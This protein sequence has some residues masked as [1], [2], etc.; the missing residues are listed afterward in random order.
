MVSRRKFK[1][2]CKKLVHLSSDIELEVFLEKE[3][4]KNVKQLLSINRN[5]CNTQDIAQYKIGHDNERLLNII[6]TQNVGL[7]DYIIKLGVRLIRSKEGD[8]F[9][10]ELMQSDSTYQNTDRK[11][12]DGLVYCS[13][14]PGAEKDGFV[15][16]YELVRLYNYNEI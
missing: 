11:E 13:I 15:I 9:D 4:D 8:V 12:L 1:K 6:L 3:R 7:E 10:P 5:I 14:L 2:K 16:D